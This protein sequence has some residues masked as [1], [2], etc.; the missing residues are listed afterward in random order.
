MGKFAYTK[1]TSLEVDRFA[2]TAPGDKCQ[3]PESI[4]CTLN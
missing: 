1:P 2:Y 4:A 3:F